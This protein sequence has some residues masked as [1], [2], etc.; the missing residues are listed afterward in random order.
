[1]TH[2]QQRLMLA[3]FTLQP[4]IGSETTIPETLSPEKVPYSL[5]FLAIQRAFNNKIL[6]NVR[7]QMSSQQMS[8]RRMSPSAVSFSGRNDSVVKAPFLAAVRISP[9]PAAQGPSWMKDIRLLLV[10]QWTSPTIRTRPQIRRLLVHSDIPNP[11]K[12]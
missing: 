4:I 8:N 11:V 7:R 1:M 5:P 12:F 9:H 3:R 2:E 6:R 10:T